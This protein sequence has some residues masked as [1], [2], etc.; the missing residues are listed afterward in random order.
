VPHQPDIRETGLPRE[1]SGQNGRMFG[2]IR[3][4]R[5]RL[6]DELGKAWQAHLCGV[7]LSL[8]DDHGHAARLATNYDGLVVSTLVEAQ[9]AA[10]P[11]RRA[12]G[13]CALRGMRG[14]AVATGDSVRLA[15]TVSLVL[16]AAKVRDHV[17][18]RDG[19]AGRYGM[20][21]AARRLA[22][23][24]SR[25]GAGVGGE[26]GFDTAVL[27]AAVDRQAEVEAGAGLGSS[28]LAVTEP[29]ET[30]T[31][32]AFGYTAVLAGRPD[33]QETLT[34]IGRLFGRVAHLLD[35]VEDLDEDA[36]SGA[37]NPLTATGTDPAEAR[38]LCEDAVLGI[39]L[40]LSEVA[41][42]DGRLVHRL[43]RE[44]LRRAIHRTFDHPARKT[45]KNGKGHSHSK[46]DDSKH[47]HS[48]H[49]HAKRNLTGA[50]GSAGSE[51]PVGS[52]GPQQ[53][54]QWPGQWPQQPGQP[55]GWPQG[56]QQPPQRPGEWQPGQW[57]G[58]QA[59][60]GYPDQVHGQGPQPGQPG[61]P[62]WMPPGA[63]RGFAGPPRGRGCGCC[64]ESCACCTCECCGD[65]CCDAV[66]S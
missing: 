16:A 15:A 43:L 27:A 49:E 40:A 56:P 51:R 31:G 18:D 53:P 20:R 63:E 4:C 24:W 12:A 62:E 66:C 55:G 25:Q 17:T 7:C 42:T 5:H 8:R 54:G 44:E 2:I 61:G 22:G 21:G 29:T 34:E 50:F 6:G 23:R 10:A 65:C 48:T 3:P 58:Q 28:P 1:L 14:A 57:P 19:V 33:N 47:D 64:G 9:C 37:W 39:E 13:P 30:A 38:R 59:G 52:Q 11:T 60:G 36:A 46:Q 26:L 45:G 41:F 35:A 32:A